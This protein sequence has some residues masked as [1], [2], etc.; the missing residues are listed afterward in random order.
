MNGIL[1]WFAR[2]RIAANLLMLLLLMGGL[3]SIGNIPRQLLPDVAHELVTVSVPYRGASPGEV[4]EAV[5]S[6]VSERLKGLQTIRRVESSA[7]EGLC[8]VVVH[9]IHGADVRQGLDDVKA[10]V[11]TIDSFPDEADEPVVEIFDPPARVL[12]VIVSGSAHERTMARLGERLYEE[13]TALPGISLAALSGVPP[14]E[15]AIEVSEERLRRYG[16]TLAQVAEAVRRSSVNLPAGSIKTRGAEM[17]VRTRGKAFSREEFESLV[18]LSREDGTRVTLGS[19]GEVTDGF[20]ESAESLRFEGQ[21]AVRID[22][23]QVDGQDFND[24]AN[25]VKDYVE[26]ARPLL[27]EAIRVTVWRD[28]TVVIRDRVSTLLVSGRTGLLLVLAVLALSLRL[29]LATWVAMGIPVSLLGTFWVMPSF[30]QSINMV[31]LVA[32]ILVLGIVVDDAL[33]VGEN[34]YRHHKE[35]KDGA[36]AAVS[37]VTEVAGPVFFS[38]VTTMTAFFPMF[39]LPGALGRQFRAV[40]IIVILCLAFSLI[41]SLLIL[42][43][44]LSHLPRTTISGAHRRGLSWSAIQIA[45]ESFLDRVARRVYLPIVDR[46]LAWRYTVFAAAIGLLLLSVGLVMGGRIPFFFFAPIE[47]DIIE[48][49]LTLPQGTPREATE[50]ALGQIEKGIQ[51][52]GE[53]LTTTGERDSVRRVLTKTGSL[54]VN[55]LMQVPGRLAASGSHLGGLALELAPAETRTVSATELGARLREV[56][57]EIPDI[58]DLSLSTSVVPVGKAIDLEVTGSDPGEIR[59][60]AEKLRNA[61]SAYPGTFGVTDSWRAGKREILLSVTPEANA[62][63]I[64]LAQLSHQVRQAFHGEEAQR[65]QRGRHEL[66]VMVRY[67]ESERRLLAS[68]ESMHIRTPAGDETPFGVVARVRLGT[69]PAAIERTD[70]RWAMRVSADVDRDAADS[71]EILRD[72]R[73]SVLPEIAS[74]HSGL[75]FAFAGD[76]QE[77]R[78]ALA[79][80]GRNAFLAL[81]AVYALLAIGSSS[82]AQPLVVML[83]IPFGLI[84]AIW[85]H[86]IMGFP[87]TLTSLLGM[88]ALGGVVVNDGLVLTAF[89]NRSHRAGAPLA[90]ALREAGQARFRPIVLASLTTFAGL[91]PL[92]FSRSLQARFLI[93]I[94]ISLAFGVLFATCIS[95]LLVPVGYRILEDFRSRL[96]GDLLSAGAGAK[97][98]TGGQR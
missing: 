98:S 95:L 50:A 23:F 60:A 24:V 44:H 63:G 85:G 76:Q 69:G 54:P 61:L 2:N 92:I 84:G 80:L 73:Q 28:T 21:R 86:L 71:G 59:V 87:L 48:V 46:A 93:P 55:P 91:A 78:D 57:G 77:Q 38:V 94:G 49:G 83:S 64:S 79:S 88:V 5:C 17:L 14:Y 36:D 56:V 51:K 45:V 75:N 37:G 10:R 39:G 42:P 15:I 8:H 4:D 13:I 31:S 34:I 33:V 90:E 81:F 30:G 96:S 62:L 35:G 26:Q 9:L 74:A 89:I 40:P 22:V 12:S 32:L 18:V 72:L 66:R 25:R 1:I 6:L 11:D 70:G 7:T 53:E 82:Y 20:A 68:L 47:S 19:V 65:I 43:A 97:I 29:R 67:P 41:E 16:L 52:L 58:V 3:F 27:P